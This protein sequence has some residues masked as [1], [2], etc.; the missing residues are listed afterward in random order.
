M[1]AMRSSSSSA[2]KLVR[3]LASLAC[4]SLAAISQAALAGDESSFED[5]HIFGFT[6]GAD[7]GRKGEMEIE[8]TFTSRFGKGGHYHALENE[9][10][11]RYGVADGVRTSLGLL[12]DTHVVRGVPGLPDLRATNFNGFSSE[13]RWQIL[14]SHQAPFGLTLSLDPQWRRIDEVSGEPATTYEIPATLLVDT[15][16]IANMLFGAAN[17]TY[18]PSLARMNGSWQRDSALE[19]SAAISGAIRPGVFVGAELRH[20]ST[21]EGAF[22]NRDEAQTLFAGPS[23]FVQLRGG[24]TVK[25]AWSTR[26]WGTN[27]AAGSLNS[28]TFERNQVRA[29]IVKTF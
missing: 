25:A 27:S 9:T 7:I 10:A 22:L 19:V 2:L 24:F 21:Y 26:L 5:E 14:S 6:E 3:V 18:S 29:Q 13:T 17:L 15:E 11:L 1:E 23:L 28:V 8:S 12:A 20:L 16:I 4:F